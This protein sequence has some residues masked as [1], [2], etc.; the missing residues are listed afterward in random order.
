MG[1]LLSFEDSFTWVD[2]Q[3]RNEH[4][5]NLSI[6]L[7][8]AL[9]NED[10][11]YRTINLFKGANS[12]FS[13]LWGEGSSFEGFSKKYPWI[14]ESTYRTLTNIAPLIQG[15]TINDASNLKE[16]NRDFPGENNGYFGFCCECDDH[17]VHDYGTW[18]EFHRK[19][20]SLLLV[21]SKRENIK[22]IKRFYTPSLPSSGY[23]INKAIE[24]NQV[25]PVFKRLD[26]PTV[27]AD[28]QTLHNEK[29]QMH[30]N[31]EK[32]SALNIDGTWKHGGFD[33]SPKALIQLEQWGFLL[34][35]KYYS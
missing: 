18:F 8:S 4:I 11:R 30:F 13:F 2:T 33:I 25:H 22:Y 24:T 9:G 27:I 21:R 34:P 29:I 31:D 15:T 7:N 20:V 14:F 19:Y 17:L 23:Q 32:K 12:I 6:A 1:N 35:D 26:N 10:S 3:D 5:K 28:N 16:L